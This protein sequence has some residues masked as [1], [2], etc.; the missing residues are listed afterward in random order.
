[1]APFISFVAGNAI[2]GAALNR[3]RSI[4]INGEQ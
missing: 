3:D 1:M 2:K 4:V